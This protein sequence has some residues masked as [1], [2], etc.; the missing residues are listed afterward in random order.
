[1]RSWRYR[2]IGRLRTGEE[3]TIPT[4]FVLR[5]VIERE[6][7]VRPRHLRALVSSL[8]E[9]LDG[10]KTAH[11]ANIKPFSI[12][13]LRGAEGR[14]AIV[15]NML[16]EASEHHLNASVVQ[17]TAVGRPLSLGDASVRLDDPPLVEVERRS[18]TQLRLCAADTRRLTLRFESPTVFRRGRFQQHPF[19]VPDRVFGPYRDRW[20]Y[21]A[22]GLSRS[23]QPL[24]D[25]SEHGVDGD[26]ASRLVCPPLLDDDLGLTV[27]DFD[28]EPQHYDDGHYDPRRGRIVDVSYVG[29]VGTVTFEVRGRQPRPAVRRWLH[30]LAAFGEFC[31]T[32]ANTTI[33]M[34][35]TRYLGPDP[36]G[37][38]ATG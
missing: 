33:G 30:T 4:R 35:V 28:G 9:P 8:I 6:D 18:W 12:E 38:L 11:R 13:P 10:G 22:A 34:G 14:L 21:F 23:E 27:T 15:I 19:P 3:V 24:D 20:N 2:W 37:D 5:L 16:D 31:G 7:M 26:E 32:G 17:A 29:Y 1:M 36:A 25:R